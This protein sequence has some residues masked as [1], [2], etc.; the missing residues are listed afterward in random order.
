MTPSDSATSAFDYIIVGGGTAGCVVANRLSANPQ[1]RVLL[2]EAGGEDTNRWLHIPIGYA[3]VFGKP[4]FNWIYQVQPEPQLN[5]RAGPFYQGKV[6]GGSSAVNGMI[7]LRGQRED[8]DHWVQ[9]GCTGWDYGTVLKCYLRSEDQRSRAAGPY[10]SVG[11]PLA[12]SDPAEP[13]QVVD[14]FIAA[15][16][17]AGIPRNPDFNGA[18][19]EGAGYYQTMTRNG[20]RCSAAMAFIHPVKHRANLTV[21]TGARV[22]RVL[23]EGK[24]ANGVS[25][26]VNGQRLTMT[27]RREVILAAGAFA[28]PLLLQAS[29]VGPGGLLQSQGVSVVHDAPDVGQNL[30]NHFNPWISYRCKQPVTFNDQM[31]SRWGRMQLVLQYAWRWAR[32]TAVRCAVPRCRPSGPTSTSTSSC[33]EPSASSRP[34]CLSLR[35][36]P[37]SANCGPRA[38]G[39]WSWVAPTWSRT[40]R[41]G[42]TSW[43]PNSTAR[44]W[45]PAWPRCVS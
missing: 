27:A 20:R 36:W 15:A 12:V 25:V 31:A 21:M 13:H 38:V 2:L 37:R 42:S 16:E 24:D 4:E 23:F 28:S 43:P 29:G 40:R 10:H 32:C 9:L 41:S 45:P 19:Q 30:Q 26:V 44:R 33:S 7:Y 39:R 11:G 34:C 22:E 35:S 17:Q 3:R 8:F 6:I 14:A 5:N 1:H 18:T